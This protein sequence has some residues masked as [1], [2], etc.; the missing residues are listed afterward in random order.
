MG[1]RSDGK[2]I[3]PFKGS[4]AYTI[5]MEAAIKRQEALQLRIV[6]RIGLKKCDL[7]SRPDHPDNYLRR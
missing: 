2:P 1:K 3:T 7:S 4:W 6:N 5:T